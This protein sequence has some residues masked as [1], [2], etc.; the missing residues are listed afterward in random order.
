MPPTD[1]GTKEEAAEEGAKA[2]ATDTH[3]AQTARDEMEILI[4]RFGELECATKERIECNVQL[5]WHP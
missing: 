4:F 2:P 1:R 3:E 5:L